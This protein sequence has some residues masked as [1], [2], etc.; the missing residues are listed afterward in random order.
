MI[1]KTGFYAVAV[2]LLTGSM[3]VFAMADDRGMSEYLTAPFFSA[4]PEQ[5]AEQ[6]AAGEIREPMETGAVPDRS[7]GSSELFNH[8]S[9][10]EP[11]VEIGG[12]AYRPGIDLGP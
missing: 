5:G 4:Q 7:E 1:R 12:R 6:P 3:A 11:T 8:D 10:E 2:V 9:G